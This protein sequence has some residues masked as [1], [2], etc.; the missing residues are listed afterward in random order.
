MYSYLLYT[1]SYTGTELESKTGKN[2]CMLELN[3]NNNK[4]IVTTS[5]KR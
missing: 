5:N 2:R 4:N 1:L 3:K